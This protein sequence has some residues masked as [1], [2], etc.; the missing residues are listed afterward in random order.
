MRT[1]H[2]KFAFLLAVV[3]SGLGVRGGSVFLSPTLL[4][5]GLSAALIGAIGL[6]GGALSK[7]LRR[8]LADVALLSPLV[9]VPLMT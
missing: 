6:A 9:V 5:I 4:S 2:I 1:G 7:N 8:A 3:A